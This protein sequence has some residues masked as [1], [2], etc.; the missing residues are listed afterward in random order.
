MKKIHSKKIISILL[1][2]ALLTGCAF[3]PEYSFDNP[4]ENDDE[5]SFTTLG[6]APEFD[7]EV[8]E[9]LPSILVD[10]LGYPADG[11][12]IAVF[13]GES[14]PDT[15]TIIDADTG[16]SVYTGQIEQKGYDGENGVYVSYGD[17]TPFRIYGTYYISASVIGQSYTFRIAQNPYRELYDVA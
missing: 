4:P 10:Q 7:Y 6:L 17:F 15:F 12:K 9:S 16:E 13:C 3:A 11:S 8:P 2:A 5:N 14:L 1:I